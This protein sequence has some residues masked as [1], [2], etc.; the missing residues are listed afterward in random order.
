MSERK[1]D[2]A[3]NAPSG[4][5]S[6]V[7]GMR[8]RAIDEENT[9]ET[10]MMR[11]VP[12]LRGP[13]APSLQIGDS[14]GGSKT[15]FSGGLLGLPKPTGGFGPPPKLSIKKPT[16]APRS[17]SFGITNEW[18]GSGFPSTWQVNSK[19]LD[20]V[21]IDFP[22]E[23]THREIKEDAAVVASRI[24]EVLR[25]L[26]IETEFDDE[27]A[28]AKCTTSDC[29]NF[30]I[31]LY[32]GGEEGLPVVVELQRRSGS[33]GSFMRS[34]RVI[35]NA[36]EGLANESVQSQQ[37]MPPMMAKPVR[38]M[39]CLQKVIDDD[40]TVLENSRVALNGII[41]MIRSNRQDLN[42][43]GLENLCCLTDPIRSSPLGSL[44]VAKDVIIGNDN[45][46]IREELR[47]LTEHDS[48]VPEFDLNEG[49]PDHSQHLRLLAL[50]VFSNSMSLC[51]KD[52]CLAS[53]VKEQSWFAD[54]LI[55]TLID[56]V[57]RTAVSSN[58]AYEASSCLSSLVASSERAR[59]IVID[60]GAVKVLES[61]YEFGCQ[62]HE[63]LKEE[64]KRC[65]DLIS[66]N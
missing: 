39:K 11:S 14:L 38:N 55:P 45:Y 5:G 28:K 66:V 36:A 31:R 43:L 49:L 46:D 4:R 62:F 44:Q 19:D 24:S 37:K 61:A 56:E 54:C 57:K 51:S 20:L 59:Q 17:E 27:K 34:C 64:A 40:K 33:A 25:L 9:E 29:V 41:E 48:F 65:L 26:S 23:R 15:P 2:S 60:N 1:S 42:I 22:L 52:G 50:K 10:P 30:R 47:M 16:K 13:T 53:S 8:S 18:N 7:G 12:M 6:F 63:L 35:L 3:S 58:N 32:A 21:P